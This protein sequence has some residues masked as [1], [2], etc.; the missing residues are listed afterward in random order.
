M[1]KRRYHVK[2]NRY[3]CMA[4]DAETVTGCVRNFLASGKKKISQSLEE[5]MT[6]LRKWANK[7]EVGASFVK[8]KYTV[9]VVD[10][11]KIREEARLARIKNN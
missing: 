2:G 9:V 11:E 1:D 7:A 10:A 5:E 6:A 8:D 3:V 4:L